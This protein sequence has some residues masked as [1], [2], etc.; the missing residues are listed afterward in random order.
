MVRLFLCCA[1]VT[2]CTHAGNVK[3]T[4]GKHS[5]SAMSMRSMDEADPDDGFDALEDDGQP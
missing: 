2:I 4:L 3:K 5:T 1:L